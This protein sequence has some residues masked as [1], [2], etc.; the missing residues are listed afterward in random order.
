MTSRMRRAV[1]VLG[2]TGALAVVGATAGPGLAQVPSPAQLTEQGWSC[3]VHPFAAPRWYLCFNPGLGRPFPG[4]PD[5]APMYNS[6]VFEIDS[7]AFVGTG[8]TIRGDLYR[9]QACGSTGAPYA[10]LPGI[11]YYACINV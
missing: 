4:N 8:H 2:L 11:G 5:P 7:G 1:T 10:Y 9:G 3:V 6:L